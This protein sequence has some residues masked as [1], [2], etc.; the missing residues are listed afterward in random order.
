[1]GKTNRG[2]GPLEP[3]TWEEIRPEHLP[4]VLTI[5]N[6]YVENST[7]TF[8][9]RPLTEEEMRGIVF[10]NDPKHRTFVI[11]SGG[12]VCGYVLLTRF[13]AREAYDSTAEVTIYLRHGCERKGLGSRSIRFIEDYGK[14]QGFHSLMSVITGENEASIALFAGAGYEKCA[15]YRE[16]GRKFDRYLDVVCYQK[17][18]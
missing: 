17:I 16:V 14:K 3:I 7:A 5:Y 18:L 15:H 12:S 6:Y 8:H 10:F 4:E 11:L 13:K 1:M 2:S 9:T